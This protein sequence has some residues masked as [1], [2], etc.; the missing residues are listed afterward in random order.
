MIPAY[1]AFGANLGEPVATLRAAAVA[2][3]RRAGVELVAGSP[4]YRTRPIGPPGQP[5]YANAVAR[6]GTTLAAETLLDVLHD[7]EAEFGRVRDVRWGPRTLDLDL[8]WYEGDE[9]A[10]EHITLPHPRAHEREF[11]LRPL[12]DLD[13]DLVLRGRRAG[14]WLA[15]LD[16]QGV[17]ATGVA[18][19]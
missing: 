12:A 15:G 9:R 18:L 6:V 3:G 1:V 10:D 7:V 8:I 13:P 17:E 19:M 14:D 11:V 4:I 5:A 2:L 16:P